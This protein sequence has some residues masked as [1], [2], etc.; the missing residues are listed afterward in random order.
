MTRGVIWTHGVLASL[1][2]K[3]FRYRWGGFHYTRGGRPRVPL[4]SVVGAITN[5]EK[6]FLAT[7]CEVQLSPNFAASGKSK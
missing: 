1:K 7:N 3:I 5:Q 6:R 4:R 2:R